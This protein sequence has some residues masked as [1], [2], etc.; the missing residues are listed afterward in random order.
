M[1]IKLTKKMRERENMK[2]RGEN[3]EGVGEIVEEE[4]GVISSKDIC[5]YEY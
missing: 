5:V 4:I 1:G 2:L 3:K